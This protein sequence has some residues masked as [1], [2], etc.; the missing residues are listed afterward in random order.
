MVGNTHT[1]PP[2]VVSNADLATLLSLQLKATQ[3][4][5]RL[6]RR[7]HSEWVDGDTAAEMLGK[8]I[9][10]SGTHKRVLSYCEKR[11]WLKTFGQ[12]RPKTYLRTEVRDIVERVKGGLVLP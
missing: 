3:E 1:P 10:T 4:T 9:N 7:Q 6:L 11:G 8:Q 2:P 12:L 5:N